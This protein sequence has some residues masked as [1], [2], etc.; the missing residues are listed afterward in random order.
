MPLDRPTSDLERAAL[1][2][3]VPGVTI[4]EACARY[5]VTRYALQKA[6]A[7]R[8]R[9]LGRDDLILAAL[10]RNGTRTEGPL[11]DLA[12]LAAWLDYNDKDGSTAESMRADLE[13][14]AAAGWLALEGDAFRMCLPWP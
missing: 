4:A 6:R 3:C 11:G 1:L 12:L 9:R 2:S 13:R 8:S 10:T 7:S 5:G 14:L